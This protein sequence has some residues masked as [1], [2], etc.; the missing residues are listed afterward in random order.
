LFMCASE[1]LSKD[2]NRAEQQHAT[3]I[4]KTGTLAAS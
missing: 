2:R 4:A 3:E 1:R